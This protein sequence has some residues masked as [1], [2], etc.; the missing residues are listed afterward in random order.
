MTVVKRYVQGDPLHHPP[1]PSTW[2]RST[3]SSRLPVKNTGNNPGPGDE[4]PI[5]PR[6]YYPRTIK[7]GRK[8][9]EGCSSCRWNGQC[10]VL[11]YQRNFGYV[12]RDNSGGVLKFPPE[13]GTG[14]ESWNVDFPPLPS[15]AY[16]SDGLGLGN[17]FS[18]GRASEAGAFDPFR[19]NGQYGDLRWRSDF[20]WDSVN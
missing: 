17:P 9:G 4:G 15:E 12:E 3:S 13:L 16:N 5:D 6:L 20:S 2:D 11:Y 7:T 14:C 19:Y 1:I 8:R 18:D 10:K